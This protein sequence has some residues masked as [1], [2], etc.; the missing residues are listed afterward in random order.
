[1]SK[2]L[3]DFIIQAFTGYPV[4]T[5]FESSRLA[6]VIGNST[7]TISAELHNILEDSSMLLFLSHDERTICGG[8][9]QIDS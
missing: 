2:Y 9:G 5:G 1:V 3:F 7:D 8:G 4:E 6:D